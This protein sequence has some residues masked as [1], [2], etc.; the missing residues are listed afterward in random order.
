[1][2]L[3]KLLE[4]LSTELGDRFLSNLL[5]SDYLATNCISKDNFVLHWLISE[6]HYL[7]AIVTNKL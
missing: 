7:L 2:R 5:F 6:T 1:M 3:E 4:E